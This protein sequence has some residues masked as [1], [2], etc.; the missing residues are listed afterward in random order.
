[1]VEPAKIETASSP[2][3]DAILADGTDALPLSQARVTPNFFD[4]FGVTPVVGRRFL[5][6]EDQPGNDAVAIL[7]HDLWTQRFGSDPLIIGR[8]IRLNGA[9]STVVGVLPPPQ[10]ASR[11]VRT[12]ATRAEGKRG[13]MLRV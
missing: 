10:L 3:P 2:A 8:H 9:L 5:A 7:S 1:V 12:A 11:N 13:A 4:V 6:D